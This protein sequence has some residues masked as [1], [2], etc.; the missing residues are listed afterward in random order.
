M[1]QVNKKRYV[2]NVPT[3]HAVCDANYGRLLT[4]MP[5][6]DVEHLQYE[7]G[8]CDQLRYKIEIAQCA[9]YTTTVKISQVNS[10]LPAFLKPNMCVRLY[11]DAR[12]AE[13][14]QVQNISQIKA[15]YDYP[16]PDM[17]QPNEKEA[18][19]AFLSDWLIFCL[20]NRNNATE[21]QL[22]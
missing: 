2:P 22:L 16:N 10:G 13:V 12:M 21:P 9:R 3:L 14:I 11:H 8:V 18:I 6:C 5:D 17:H 1:T 4:L 15:K 19:N 7:F 20:A